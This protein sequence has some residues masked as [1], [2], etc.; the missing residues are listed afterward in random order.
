MQDVCLAALHVSMEL[1]NTLAPYTVQFPEKVLKSK[2]L[3]R[4]VDVDPQVGPLDGP[5][6]G[7]MESLLNLT[8]TARH[9]EANYGDDMP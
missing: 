7:L 2:T 6:S 4:E 1:L 8:E 3:I 5:R 9:W